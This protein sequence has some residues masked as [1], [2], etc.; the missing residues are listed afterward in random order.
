MGL[1][2]LKVDACSNYLVIGDAVAI[3]E[4]IYLY[5][6]DLIKLACPDPITTKLLLILGSVILLS[7]IAFAAFID[8]KSLLQ[9]SLD[10]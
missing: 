8:I 10:I 5:V 9:S 4:L 7:S 2:L 1:G 6:F 3:P